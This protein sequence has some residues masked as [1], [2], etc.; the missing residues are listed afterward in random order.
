MRNIEK[1]EKEIRRRY[2]Q[3]L[4]IAVDR[5][6][7]KHVKC[8]DIKCE[9]CIRHNTEC[10]ENRILIWALE[11]YK[12]PPILDEAE[13]KYLEAVI[14]PFKD[15]VLSITK[16][17]IDEG[18]KEAFIEIKVR[19]HR[20]KN[21]LDNVDLPYFDLDTMYKGMEKRNSYTLKELGLFEDEIC[22]E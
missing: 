20:N 7:K 10:E 12:E 18:S 2:E 6:T 17:C 5:R 14:K 3:G 22:K 21:L 13:K 11:E 16:Q 9:D 19:D 8:S 1:Y 15:R 4:G